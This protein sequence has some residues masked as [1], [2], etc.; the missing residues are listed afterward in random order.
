MTF[1]ACL[2]ENCAYCQDH[3]CK[4]TGLLLN[5]YSADGVLECEN[6]TKEMKR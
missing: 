5:T 4:C 2:Q 6:Y 1:V 3:V